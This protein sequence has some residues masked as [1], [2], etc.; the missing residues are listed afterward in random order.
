MGDKTTNKERKGQKARSREQIPGKTKK[1]ESTK[2]QSMTPHLN[3]KKESV[4]A[5]KACQNA[6]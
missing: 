3:K 2:K 6:R 4:P 5:K 1:D